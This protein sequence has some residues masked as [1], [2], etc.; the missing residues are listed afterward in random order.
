MIAKNLEINGRT[1]YIRDLRDFFRE[2]FIQ[3]NIDL[4]TMDILNDELEVVSRPDPNEII[5][6]LKEE[7]ETLQWDNENLED[8]L[9]EAKEVISKISNII[10][11]Y[12]M[13]F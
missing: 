3:K 12:E 10:E 1:T 7:N 13:P 4:Y 2:L 9:C 6:D 8:E 5:E 11:S